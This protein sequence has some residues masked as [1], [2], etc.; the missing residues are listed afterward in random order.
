MTAFDQKITNQNLVAETDPYH[1]LF[2]ETNKE[3][4]CKKARKKALEVAFKNLCYHRNYRT[5]KALE[6]NK[7][8]LNAYETFLMVEWC[9]LTQDILPPLKNLFVEIQKRYDSLNTERTLNRESLLQNLKREHVDEE[10]RFIEL[11][12]GEYSRLKSIVEHTYTRADA[13]QKEIPH[14]N[15]AILAMLCITKE[16]PE[17]NSDVTIKDDEKEPASAT[18][19]LCKDFCESS[20][21]GKT[22]KIK[23]TYETLKNALSDLTSEINKRYEQLNVEIA[24]RDAALNNQCW[25]VKSLTP[26]LAKP[27]DP[28]QLSP[29]FIERVSSFFKGASNAFSTYSMTFMRFKVEEARIHEKKEDEKKA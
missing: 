7:I 19:E 17:L 10:I 28:P 21:Q 23:E 2:V 5:E 20:I 12:Y 15:A 27:I 6:W 22:K 8:V 1:S 3:P 24:L 13:I 16:A 14:R 26:G 29:S 4:K 11:C 9:R 25:P 18:K